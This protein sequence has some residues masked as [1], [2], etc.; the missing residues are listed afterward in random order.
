MIYAAEI[1]PET[2]HPR[3]LRLLAKLPNL[4]QLQL[5]GCQVS[6]ALVP[7]LLKLRALRGIG[8]EGTSLSPAALEALE[9]LPHL[10]IIER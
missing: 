3:L 9:Q 8:L 1:P 10:E 6:D 7:E 4:E 2:F 5:R